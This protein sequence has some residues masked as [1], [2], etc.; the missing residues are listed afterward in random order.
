MDCGAWQ[1]LL[2]FGALSCPTLAAQLGLDKTFLTFFLKTFCNLPFKATINLVFQMKL[3][4][5]FSPVNLDA[6]VGVKLQL[7]YSELLRNSISNLPSRFWEVT[8]HLSSPCKSLI[9]QFSHV[10]I[11]SC[12]VPFDARLGAGCHQVGLKSSGKLQELPSRLV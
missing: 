9:N 3:L 8:I 1:E 10:L 12:T 6:F 2:R 7:I 11:M 5:Y 4:V